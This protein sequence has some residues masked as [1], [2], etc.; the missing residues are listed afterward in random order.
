M[1]RSESLT[2]LID[3]ILRSEIKP[4]DLYKCKHCNGNVRVKFELYSR[5]KRK[6]LGVIAGC[7]NCGNTLALDLDATDIPQWLMEEKR[8]S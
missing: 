4:N 3:D 2:K 1:E 5:G 8:D 6:M 7:D